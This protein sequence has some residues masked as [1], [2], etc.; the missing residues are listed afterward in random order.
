M[1]SRHRG[2]DPDLWP[3]DRLQLYSNHIEI[4]FSLADVEVCFAQ[5]LGPDMAMAPQ[6]WIKTSPVHLVSFGHAINEAIAGYESQYGR[7][8]RSPG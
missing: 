2:R 4:S 8:P 1:T 5:N 6:S 3:I 7:I